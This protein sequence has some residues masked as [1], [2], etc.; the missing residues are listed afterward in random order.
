MKGTR[1][2]LTCLA[3]LI[4]LH[5]GAQ[6]HDL[7][8]KL[9][10]YIDQKGRIIKNA[11]QD[12]TP[13]YISKLTDSSGQVIKYKVEQAPSA[14][15]TYIVELESMPLVNF[16]HQL[17]KREHVVS[18]AHLESQDKDVLERQV[19]SYRD[20]IQQLQ[21]EVTTNIK[22]ITGRSK[23]IRR[24][25]RVSNALVLEA[26]Q[27]DIEKIKALAN[28]RRVT[29]ERR[30][31]ITLADSLPLV[32]APNVW[33]L[34]DDQDMEVK[35]KGVSVA[36]LDTG[37]DYTHPALGGCLGT[38]CKVVAG[39]DFVNNDGDPMDGHGHGT[40]V[41][42]I[43]GANGDSLSGVA[44]DV[45]LY[46]YKVL[47]DGGWGSNTDII[48]AIEKAV[49]P[50][51]DP[52]THDAVDIINMSLG[53]P[54]E[55]DGPLS[56]AVNNAVDAGVI[57]VVA[58]GN[59][60]NYGDINTSSPAN[61]EKAIT[62][63][64]S[65]KSDDLS[66]F[67]S[68]GL[69][70]QGLAIK[71]EITAP[72]SDIVSSYLNGE[73]SSM[74][75]TSMAS[76]HVAGAVALLK[77][78]WPELTPQQAKER[79]MAGAR[80]LGLD[81]LSQGAGRMDIEASSQV[82]LFSE[83]GIVHFGQVDKEAAS[84]QS[85]QSL[86]IKNTADTEQTYTLSV[87]DEISSGAVLSVSSEEITLAANS[88]AS[89]DISV[90]IQDVAGFA[91]PEN[92]AGIF[93]DEIEIS[94]K[95][96]TLTVPLVLDHA[97]TLTIS[98][99]AP[100]YTDVLIQSD[101]NSFY[102]WPSVNTGEEKAIRV[103]NKPLNIAVQYPWLN[104]SH[105][106][107][108]APAGSTVFGYETYALTVTEDTVLELDI[109]NLTSVVGIQS[110]NGVDGESLAVSDLFSENMDTFIQTGPVN[111][112]A[113]VWWG[114]Q[115]YAA[116][117]NLTPE[118]R[119]TF[120]SQYTLRNQDTGNDKH[121][122]QLWHK[123][124]GADIADVGYHLDLSLDPKVKINFAANV[125]NDQDIQFG[126]YKKGG[127]MISVEQPEQ[128]FVYSHTDESPDFTFTEIA[129]LTPNED[130]GW[131]N[132]IASTSGMVFNEDGGINKVN[133]FGETLAS[134]EQ[135]ELMVDAEGLFWS[136]SIEMNTDEIRVADY[137]FS[138]S[139]P[140]FITDPLGNM[141]DS[142]LNTQ[143]KWL[144]QQEE[145][146]N[147]DISVWLDSVK[148]FALP[149]ASCEDLQIVFSFDSFLA[150]EKYR[151]NVSYRYSEYDNVTTIKGIY[152]YE[153]DKI[154]KDQ[155]LNKL[156]PRIDIQFE[157]Q[158]TEEVEGE[159]RMD[160]GDWQ[161]VS[162]V[163][164][165]NN[166]QSANI[167]MIT[168]NHVVDLRLTYL[169]GNGN[170]V[171]QTLNGFFKLGTESGDDKDLDDDGIANGEDS[172]LDNDG[173][174]NVD[175]V[176]PLNP[177]EW[178]DNDN[179]GIG[180][181]ADTDDDNDGVLDDQDAFPLDPSESLDTDNDGI[182]NNA[183]TDDDNDGVLDDQDA[184]PLDPSESVDTD[185][186]GTGNNADIDDDNDGVIDDQDAF[187]LDA[188]ESMDTDSDGIGNNAD[189]DD[190]NDGVADS[191]DAFP[192]DASESVDT[193]GDGIG[194]NADTDDDNDGVADSSDAY[195]L[196]ASRSELPK[197]DSSSGS[198][199]GSMGLGLVLMC[200]ALRRRTRQQ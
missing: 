79:L 124:S 199:G 130:K 176:F 60:G 107:N 70:E 8:P 150:G 65:T 92:N 101:D 21:Q 151:S 159:V 75:G 132:L 38:D 118:T 109:G 120:D 12:T 64:S 43:V 200:L 166:G 126:M 154:V 189:T 71:P 190:D 3:S 82:S 122:Y 143:Y 104:E 141:Y 187:P 195:P 145:L 138:A 184:F 37:I 61:A 167:E 6:S 179:D 105:V 86:M 121:I 144:C 51:G 164:N 84:W 69:P 81:P 7:D 131:P 2:T 30:F 185:G 90:S 10:V 169:S 52:L 49:D 137:A 155:T 89:V 72:G 23:V 174:P 106:D 35:G 147:G 17:L 162:F 99:N 157:Y 28:V 47:S 44:P 182:G 191:N 31:H 74:S 97:L 67:S 112:S 180:D 117:G 156:S 48:A 116:Y 19:L 68:K 4:S 148:R 29:P 33:A 129:L 87:P 42:G 27:G 113:G 133:Y 32:N 40:H 20:E 192:L 134:I 57:V 22:R 85:T 62:V 111:L 188:T 181:N 177:N 100:S 93:F 45:S 110:V 135:R 18:L 66:Y 139:Q 63:A 161:P 55:P 171:V 95:L 73:T 46:G 9:G 128:V 14:I 114:G 194:N 11:S 196:D 170:P 96:Q 152:L 125:T 24:F 88:Q 91:Y 94:S 160:G 173:V 198:G 80:D 178:A 140:N 76:P 26:D 53:G 158:Q 83:P 115:L 98:S 77:Q 165:D 39:Y 13:T 183:D 153:G 175:D 5:L 56:S 78:L 50:D 197:Q 54:G 149:E 1:F 119:L 15:Q 193:D 102:S 58:A 59:N 103:P 123:A 16:K 136:A 186:D 34:K 127:G 163:F 146:G 41:A 168:G 36:I 25:D 108:K 172:D 142:G